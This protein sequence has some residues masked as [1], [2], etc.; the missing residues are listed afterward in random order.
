MTFAI[1]FTYKGKGKG[2]VIYVASNLALALTVSIELEQFT[3]AVHQTNYSSLSHFLKLLVKNSWSKFSV[4][5]MHDVTLRHLFNFFS[6]PRASPVWA[7]HMCLYCPVIPFQTLILWILVSD[8]AAIM[9]FQFSIMSW[10]FTMPFAL[11]CLAVDD[12]TGNSN[13]L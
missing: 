5:M 2:N 6:H 8:L 9:F 3:A 10:C 11:K 13:D 12:C 7:M 1:A 4:L